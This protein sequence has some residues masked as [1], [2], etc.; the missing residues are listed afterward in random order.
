MVTRSR[1]QRTSGRKKPERLKREIIT[2]E[3][4]VDIKGWTIPKGATLYVM[5][6]FTIRAPDGKNYE[7]LTVRVDNGTGILDLMP[8][9]VI[10]RLAKVQ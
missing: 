9:T 5:K 10:K 3:D 7:F 1:L 6:E 4:I 2:K 8:E